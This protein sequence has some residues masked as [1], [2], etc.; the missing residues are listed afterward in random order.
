MK[1]KWAGHFWS[2]DTGQDLVEYTLI[3]AIFALMTVGLVG[4]HGP[5]INR[6][7]TSMT[8]HLTEGSTVAAGG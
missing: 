3:L 5:A 1:A 4:G 8:S 6:V 7:W 2:D